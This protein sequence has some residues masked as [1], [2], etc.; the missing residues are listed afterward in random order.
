MFPSISHI[1]LFLYA[2]STQIIWREDIYQFFQSKEKFLFP[3]LPKS[4]LCK[5][6]RKCHLLQEASPD[7]LPL[8]DLYICNIVFP[9]SLWILRLHSA[10]SF[11]SYTLTLSRCHSFPGIKSRRYIPPST[12]ELSEGRRHILFH[13][14][15]YL[16]HYS[17]LIPSLIV[18]VQ[19]VPYSYMQHRQ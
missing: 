14:S 9:S 4:C 7:S 8:H 16:A 3:Y 17:V 12:L 1:Y 10:Q 13:L 11:P 15:P 19:Y 18:N 5:F 2:I 6:H